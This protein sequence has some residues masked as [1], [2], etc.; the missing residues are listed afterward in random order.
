MRSK[1][2][3]GCRRCFCIGRPRH[4]HDYIDLFTYILHSVLTD[5]CSWCRSHHV[6]HVTR[7][8]DDHLMPT[9]R[10]RA[11]AHT[12]HRLS[13]SSTR[14]QLPGAATAT[15]Q[16]PYG[17]L[18]LLDAALQSCPSLPGGKPL[19]LSLSLVRARRANRRHC[20]GQGGIQ[21]SLLTTRGAKRPPL[22]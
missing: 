19:Q 1:R 17:G 15:L 14:S 7:A 6:S 12:L 20:R 18:Y 9:S 10:A 5:V 3:V 4:I 13:R 8:Q 21:V 2:T 22:M 11:C 16:I